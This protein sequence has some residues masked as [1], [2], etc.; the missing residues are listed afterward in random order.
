M[1]L[2]QLQRSTSHFSKTLSRRNRFRLT[3]GQPPQEGIPVIN[4]EAKPMA[5]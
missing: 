4:F 5:A 1:F 3:A 2:I